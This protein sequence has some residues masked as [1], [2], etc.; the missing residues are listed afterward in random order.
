MLPQGLARRAEVLP[1]PIAGPLR[2]ADVATSKAG[3]YVPL[4]QAAEATLALLAAVVLRDAGAEGLA[5]GL[6]KPDHAAHASMGLWRQT[7]EGVAHKLKRPTLP[8]LTAL[9]ADAGRWGVF[10]S[11]VGILVDAR[12]HFAHPIKA[13]DAVLA[14]RELPRCAEAL[15]SVLAML[16]ALEQVTL[17]RVVARG[18]T[19]GRLQVV[20]LNGPHATRSPQWV[21]WADPPGP[22]TVLLLDTARGRWRDLAPLYRW[23]D[24]Q[25]WAYTRTVRDGDGW[26]AHWADCVQS[27]DG[28]PTQ[29]PGPGWLARRLAERAPGGAARLSPTDAVALSGGPT[30]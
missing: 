4:V 30:A 29:A 20:P 11:A 14:E 13:V 2:R 5:P 3:A 9:R 8:E 12:N 22:A 21:T 23:A 25:L 1:L 10:N 17:V 16:P 24:D 19:D 28:A 7:L 27:K 15:R 6:L 18:P 26:Q